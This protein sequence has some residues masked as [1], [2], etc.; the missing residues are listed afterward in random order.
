MSQ[1]EGS[2]I[3]LS[4]ANSDFVCSFPLGRVNDSSRR[5]LWKEDSEL[6]AKALDPDSAS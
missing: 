2:P 1:A 5:A 4:L 6:T 3:P